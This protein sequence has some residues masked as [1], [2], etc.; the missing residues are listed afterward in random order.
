[1]NIVR[2]QDGSYVVEKMGIP[3]HIPNFGEWEEGWKK[4]NDY[5]LKHPEEVVEEPAPVEPSLD[6]IKAAKLYEI[7]SSYDAITSS[8]VSTYPSTE[9]LT[10]DKQEMEARARA[11]DPSANTPFLDGLAKA[12]GIALDDLV[13]RVIKKSE[14]F[15][16]AVASLTGQ[17]QRYEDLLDS[18]QTAEEVSAIVPEYV[19]SQEG[20]Q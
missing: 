16:A 6:E 15:A 4:V 19:T 8:L 3:C 2:R 12:R 7:N 10:F 20:E 9:L 5:A 14:A 13:V 17:R 18:A 11:N 1:M